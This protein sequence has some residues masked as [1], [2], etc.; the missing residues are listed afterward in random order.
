MTHLY[1]SHSP[2]LTS[3]DAALTS[4]MR[5]I[6]MNESTIEMGA[7]VCLKLSNQGKQI[8]HI[9]ECIANIDHKIDVCETT[10]GKM[11]SVTGLG[12]WHAVGK[13]FS[14]TPKVND[15]A[16][17]KTAA[18]TKKRFFFKKK[19]SEATQKK[20]GQK[21]KPIEPTHTS[22]DQIDTALDIV[23]SQIKTIKGISLQISSELGYHNELLDTANHAANIALTNVDNVIEGEENLL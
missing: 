5:T 1:P 10:V 6:R 2:K 7:D 14:R 15:I 9:T 4:L 13:L 23:D 18:K 17:P 19:E 21:K 3:G 11:N 8:N 16:N 12:F 20:H 22:R